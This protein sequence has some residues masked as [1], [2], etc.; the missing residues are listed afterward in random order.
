MSDELEKLLEAAR[1]GRYEPHLHDA[2]RFLEKRIEALETELKN[3]TV[4]GPRDYYPQF[5][6]EGKLK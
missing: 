3:S 1:I 4:V 6:A 5:D 2:L